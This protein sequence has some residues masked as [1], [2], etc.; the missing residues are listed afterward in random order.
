MQKILT[1]Q[2]SWRR[3]L[4]L[5]SVSLLIHTG[6]YYTTH[7]EGNLNLLEGMRRM[8][9]GALVKQWAQWLSEEHFQLS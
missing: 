1:H 5:T 4:V 9:R 3:S 8:A 6:V 7:T 2:S